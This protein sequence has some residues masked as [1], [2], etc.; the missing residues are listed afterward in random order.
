MSTLYRYTTSSS[1]DVEKCS[2]VQSENEQ[3]EKKYASLAR[4]SA[5]IITVYPVR[6]RK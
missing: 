5:Q 3:N 2:P 4:M 1:R 6:T